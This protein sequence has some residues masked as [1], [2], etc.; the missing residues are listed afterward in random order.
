MYGLDRV[1]Y[2]F[3]P[4]GLYEASCYDGFQACVLVRRLQDE[5]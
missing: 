1:V 4:E 2:S 3:E 5:R